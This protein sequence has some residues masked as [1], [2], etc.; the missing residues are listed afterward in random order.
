MIRVSQQLAALEPSQ[1]IRLDTQAKA[2]LA[3]GK[4]VINLSVGELD[5][6]P[7]D[8][9]LQAAHTAVDGGHNHYSSPQG[10]LETRQAV[11]EYLDKH[12]K[13]QY[14]PEEILITNGAKQAIFAS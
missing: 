1:T 3:A 11:R 12:H 6:E 14:S 9:I 7:P 10:L 5:F 2:M 13:L 8:A 4:S